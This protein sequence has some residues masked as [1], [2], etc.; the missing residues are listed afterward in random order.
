VRALA[1]VMLVAGTAAASPRAD[2]VARALTSVH[3]LGP[4]GR[5]ALDRAVYESTRTRCRTDAGPPTARCSIDAARAACDGAAD[6]AA[7]EAAADVIA[8]DLR[9]ASELVDDAT[10][11][12][13]VRGSTDY[14][15]ALA[16]ELLRRYALL[17]AELAVTSPSADGAAIDSFCAH[18]DAEPHACTPGDAGCVPPLAWPRCVAALVWYVG[19]AP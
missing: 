11:A 19:S 15:A 3:A 13:L 8:T 6:H 2:Y 5:A 1:I 7:C 10:R 17:A 4:D 14:H 9:G 18:R 12:R 16:A